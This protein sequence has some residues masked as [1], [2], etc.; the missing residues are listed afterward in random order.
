MFR[1]KLQKCERR[2]LRLLEQSIETMVSVSVV[3]CNSSQVQSDNELSTISEIV[4]CLIRA[5]N[6]EHREFRQLAREIAQRLSG[7]LVHVAAKSK[8]APDQS[9]HSVIPMPDLRKVKIGNDDCAHV[10][11]SRMKLGKMICIDWRHSRPEVDVA[12]SVPNASVQKDEL[13][14]LQVDRN[15]IQMN[16]D[17]FEIRASLVQFEEPILK[18]LREG[19]G[20]TPQQKSQSWWKFWN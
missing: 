5:A 11:L 16:M 4:D 10:P 18:L 12:I 7:D 15:S 17:E 6:M 2:A 14:I 13:R 8:D 3:R 1:A 9:I 20:A 19:I